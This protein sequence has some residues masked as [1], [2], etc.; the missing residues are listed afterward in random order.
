MI[1]DKNLKTANETGDIPKKRVP[2]NY[3]K[4]KPEPDQD[5]V[6]WCNCLNPKLVSNSGIRGQAYC[7]LCNT[8]WY[9]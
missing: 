2:W 4:R 3:G 9:H 5:G 8:P 1:L 7:L 6:L